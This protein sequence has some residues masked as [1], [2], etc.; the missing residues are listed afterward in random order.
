MQLFA[1]MKFHV[2]MNPSQSNKGLFWHP[3]PAVTWLS[4][5]QALTELWDRKDTTKNSVFWKHFIELPNP[6]RHIY[7]IFHLLGVEKQLLCSDSALKSV[8]SY[9]ISIRAAWNCMFCLEGINANLFWC[10][11]SQGV[12]PKAFG[13][14]QHSDPFKHQ[15]LFFQH[16]AFGLGLNSPKVSVCIQTPKS[17]GYTKSFDKRSQFRLTF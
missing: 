12:L 17:S 1:I 2:L 14:E 9:Y 16:K 4:R 6:F 3:R 8:N 10:F 11:N 5:G 7:F 13:S 15:R